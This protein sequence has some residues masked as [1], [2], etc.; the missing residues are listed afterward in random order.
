M[1]WNHT[2][3]SK[4]NHIVKSL[5]AIQTEFG[6]PLTI[7]YIDIPKVNTNQVLIKVLATGLCHSQLHEFDNPTLDRPLLNGHEAVG[8]IVEIGPE[9]K[10]V[11]VG[12]SVL[13]T[14]VPRK[15]FP[16]WPEKQNLGITYSGQKVHNLSLYAFS[17]YILT[18]EFKVVKINPIDATPESSIVGCA[19]LTG[20]GAVLNTAKVSA[21]DSVVIFGAGGVGLSAIAMASLLHAYPI[22]AIDIDETKLNFASEFGATHTINSLKNDPIKSILDITNGGA[23]FAF[24]AIGLKETSESLLPSLR[25]GGPRHD[26]TGG[27]A[28]LIGLGQKHLSLDPK[29]FWFEHKQFK[30]STGSTNPDKD[31]PLF[32]RWYKEGKLPLNKLITRK[33]SIND[34]NKAFNELSSGKILGRSIIIFD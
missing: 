2:M 4:R 12:D 7:D 25:Q 23:D 27:T 1:V 19:I 21:G 11:N 5:A 17:E 15:Y 31:F 10:S 28:V 14:W 26:N 32:L 8:T 24:D 34:I 18:Q 30:G 6:K 3:W 13:V 33:Y 9:T 22:I 16:G 29:H 20:A